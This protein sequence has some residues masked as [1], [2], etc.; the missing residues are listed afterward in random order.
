MLPMRIL[1]KLAGL[2]L[3]VA[4][5]A[6][7]DDSPPL[8]TGPSLNPASCSGI[9]LG[10]RPA[11]LSVTQSTPAALQVLGNGVEADRYTAEVAVRGTTAYTTTWNVRRAQGNKVNIWDVS[12]NV[13]QL[14]DSV[15]VTGAVT[16]G[17]V[18]VSDDGKLLVV[19]TELSP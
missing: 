18:A 5:T 9:N 19:A 1:E 8:T 2:S 16:T 6:C 7:G 11:A 4:L 13:P 15:I 10:P 14:V 17:D 3:V 12:G